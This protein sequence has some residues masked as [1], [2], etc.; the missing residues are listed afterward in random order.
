MILL[1]MDT[2]TDRS[3]IAVTDRRGQILQ[4]ITD[5]G[6]RHGRDLIPQLKALLASA[7]LEPGEIQAI[8]VG[9]GPGSYTGS[10]VGVTAA[11]ALGLTIPSTVLALADEVIE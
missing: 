9:L 2:T 11:K 7:Q 5:G 8:A 10:R 3:V 1:A 6:R 4:A